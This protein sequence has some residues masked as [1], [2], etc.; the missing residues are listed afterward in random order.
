MKVDVGYQVRNGGW[1]SVGVLEPG[2]GVRFCNAELELSASCV[3]ESENSAAYEL[4]F[5]CVYPTRIRLL[6]EL[7]GEN[8]WHLIPCCIHGDNN[9]HHARPDQYPNLT[10]EY[11]EAEYSSPLWEFRADRAS[12]PVS[13]LTTECAAGAV[14]IAPYSYDLDGQFIRNGVFAELPNRFGVTF[15]YANLPFTF[16][17]KRCDSSSGISKSTSNPLC[18]GRVAGKLFHY[19]EGGRGA[20]KKIIENLYRSSRECPHFKHSFREA[21]RAVL[22]AFVRCNYSAEFNHYTLVYQ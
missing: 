10:R 11:P 20:V 19:P 13:I 15:G 16:V 6:A 3:P 8:P 14:S 4:E 17:N 18:G 21:A 5:R 22:D 1:R 12:H 7:D 9:L 2:K